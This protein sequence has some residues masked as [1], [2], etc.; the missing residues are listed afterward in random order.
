MGIVKK[1]KFDKIF[2]QSMNWGK[3]YELGHDKDYIYQTEL[4]NK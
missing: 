1:N 2:K 4:L 3:E